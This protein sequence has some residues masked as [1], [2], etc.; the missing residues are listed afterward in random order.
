MFKSVVFLLFFSDIIKKKVKIYFRV[1]EILMKKKY[2]VKTE[3]DF[4]TVIN[5]KKSCAN[6]NL[7]LFVLEKP[8]QTHFRYGLSVGKKIGNAVM[9]NKV[10]RQL[11][12]SIYQLRADLRPDIDFVLIARQNINILTTQ[13]VYDNLLH[14]CKLG[15]IL[16]EDV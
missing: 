16:K 15:N 8:E 1:R 6:R 5:A 7:V 12:E 10:K 4:Q 9:R 13:E 14:I 2:H 3:K 11:R